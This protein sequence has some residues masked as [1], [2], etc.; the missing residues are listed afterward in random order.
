MWRAAR[1]EGGGNSNYFGAFHVPSVGLCRPALAPAVVQMPSALRSDSFYVPPTVAATRTVVPGSSQVGRVTSST[2][3][4]CMSAPLCDITNVGSRTVRLAGP[5]EPKRIVPTAPSLPYAPSSA[6]STAPPSSAP[7]SARSA[8]SSIVM[9]TEDAEQAPEYIE[10]MLNGLFNRQL[11]F[12]PMPS[13]MDSQ[14]HIDAR[15]RGI[16]V[17]WLVEVQVKYK[18]SSTALFL[19]VNLIDRYL[20]KKQVQ[21]QRLQLVGVAAMFVA[22]K[23]EELDPPT[24]A[25]LVYIT[26]DAYSKKELLAMECSFLATLGFEVTAPTAQH[27]LEHF[28][29]SSNGTTMGRLLAQ[30]ILE[31]TLIDIRM[32]HYRP[33]ELAAASLCL[34]NELAGIR[35]V[36]PGSLARCARATEEALRPIVAELRAALD[37]ASCHKLQAIRKKY[38]HKD[39]LKV[40]A[41]VAMR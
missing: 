41:R 3:N 13:Y 32:L 8:R 23:F 31:L 1:P 2:W 26:D 27:F 11:V 10:D 24:A 39:R 29:R 37:G 15:M 4:F 6:P 14:P 28:D 25:N 12:M 40:S 7:S 20:S 9:A 30:Y 16:L 35:P 36:W 22:A 38:A 21:R 19:T 17:D 18:M 33:S 34:S 5:V